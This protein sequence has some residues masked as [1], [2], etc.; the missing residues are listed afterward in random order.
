MSGFKVAN[1]GGRWD[2]NQARMARA[3]SMQP[4]QQAAAIGQVD[5]PVEGPGAETTFNAQSSY[6]FQLKCQNGVQL[7][8]WMGDRWN[9]RG[10]GG[11]S[12]P[13]PGSPIAF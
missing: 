2:P 13:P 10:P 9:L 5:N 7:F 11:V 8:V 4:A 12:T 1:G 3:S 6:V